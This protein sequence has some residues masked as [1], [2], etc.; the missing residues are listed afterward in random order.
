[1][2]TNLII[3]EPWKPPDGA[4]KSR[5][6]ETGTQLGFNPDKPGFKFSQVIKAGF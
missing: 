1:M 3:T 5:T 4:Q 6:P 2:I